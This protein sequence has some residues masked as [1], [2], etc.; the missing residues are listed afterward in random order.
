MQGI[1]CT[2]TLNQPT[3]LSMI[4]VPKTHMIYIMQ[5]NIYL[6]DFGLATS[7]SKAQP[8]NGTRKTMAPEVLDE[9]TK[10]KTFIFSFFLRNW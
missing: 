1:F 6:A 10:S 4:K 2:W 9:N 7:P 8:M 3:F 5:D